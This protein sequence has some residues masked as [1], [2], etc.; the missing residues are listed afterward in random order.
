MNFLGGCC[1]I[2]VGA[3]SVTGVAAAQA[4]PPRVSLRWAAPDECPDDVQLVHQI[5]ALLGQ[6]LLDAGEQAL[7]VRASAQ[8]NP[9]KGYAAKVSFTGAQGTEERYLE[10]PSCENL[11][12]ALAL[13]I[14]LAID[15][16]RV[17]ATQ[18]TR[19]AQAEVIVVPEQPALATPERVAPPAR[20][21]ERNTAPLAN[22]DRS[23]PLRGLRVAL[24][25]AVGAGP[26]PQLGAGVEATLGWHRQGFRVELVGR[27]WL[28]QQRAVPDFISA[29]L[30][31]GL[32]TLG[33]RACWQPLIGAWQVAACAGGDLGDMSARG[34]A[35]GLRDPRTPHALYADLAGGFQLAYAR[36]RLAPEGGF[37]VSG[38]LSRP[39]FGIGENGRGDEVFRPETWGFS[40][41]FGLAFE[42]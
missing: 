3:L 2:A 14:A 16:E 27:Y 9:D 15:P 8:G 31:L 39:L 25:G 37:E 40:A 21:A 5:E 34:S 22:A 20:A 17:R 42:L 38:A 4:L 6:S 32:N 18:Q 24:H 33:A 35:N 28:S 13:V 1:L 23:S 10:H 26:L 19:D 41:F 29:S 30:Q 36:S 12:Q 11:V 7:A